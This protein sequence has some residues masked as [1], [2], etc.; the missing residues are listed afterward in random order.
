MWVVKGGVVDYDC[1]WVTFEKEFE[2]QQEAEEF[3]E[4]E[5]KLNSLWDFVRVEQE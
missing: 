5:Q 1:E 4:K 2:T 3:A